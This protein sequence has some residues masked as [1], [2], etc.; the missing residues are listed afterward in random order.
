MAIEFEKELGTM[1]FDDIVEYTLQSIIQKNAGISNINPGSVLRTLTEVFAENE[2]RINYYME[3]V[4]RC[5]NIDNCYGNDL[6][7]AVK[8]LG[9]TR[10]NSKAAV[11]EV[12]FS[13]GDNV[14][15]YDI[16]I[17]YGYIV[18]TRPNRDGDVTEFYVSDAKAVLKSGESQINVTVTCTNPGLIYIPI[19][20]IS[21]MSQSLQGINSVSNE[22]VINGGRDV[23]TDEEF[24]ERISNVRETFGKCTNEAIESA[25]DQVQGV[26]KARVIDMYNGVG[27]TGVIVVTDTVPPPD[28]VKSEIVEV[29][30]AVKASG[31]EPFI[32]YSNIKDVDIEIEVTGVELTDEDY[33]NIATAINKYCTSLSAGQDFIIRQMERKALN[34]IDKSDTENDTADIRTIY[35]TNNLTSSDEQII[36]SSQIKIN[37]II[38]SSS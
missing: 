7:R 36:R 20:A 19:G 1:S 11:G 9:L 18:S 29:V 2:D 21:V 22:H 33:T 23:E 6:D 10:G 14:A 28:S 26:T 34:A 38:V 3:Y 31:V 12:T 4:Y 35:P 13:T 27:T 24:K 30:N 17:P 16:E 5:M 8:V 37:G 25:V 32:I 15:E